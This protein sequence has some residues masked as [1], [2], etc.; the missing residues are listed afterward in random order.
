M[1]VFFF[2]VGLE[3]RREIH[4]GEL[5]E[6]RR[7]T[8]PLAVA[9]GGM[10]APAL[11]FLALNVGRESIVGWAV[12]TATDIAFAVGALALLGKR[13][14]PAMRVLLLALAVIDDVGAIVV[15]ALFYSAEISSLGFVVVG[16]GVLLILALHSLGIRSPVPYILPGITVWAGM[17]LSGIH[18]TLAGVI[19]GMMTPVTAELGREA[20]SPVERLEHLLHG[21]VALLIM[22]VFAF[23]NAG[24]TVGEISISGEALWV[25]LGITIGLTVGKPAGIL[26]LS[27][28]AVRFGAAALRTGWVGARLLL[29]ESLAASGSQCRCSLRS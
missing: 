13:V 15:I 10:L 17:Y 7:A 29:W 25:F 28:L 19:V 9:F 3:S 16:I 21:W 2:V 8:L 18:P 4:L 11:I 1:T 24:L 6:L 23:A 26:A 12:P 20:V 22:P 14:T 27:W 5:S